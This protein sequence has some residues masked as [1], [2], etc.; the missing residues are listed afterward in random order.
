MGILIGFGSKA[1]QGK[2]TAAQV[3]VDHLDLSGIPVATFSF[4]EALYDECRRF[5]GMTTKDAP[6][7]QKVGMDRRQQNANYW[8]NKVLDGLDT[9][10]D[11]YDDGVAL[12]TDVRFPNEAE[13]IKKYGGYLVNVAR[14]NDDGTP[15]IAPDRPADHPSEISLDN[16]NWDFRIITHSGEEELAADLVLTVFNYIK[17]IHAE[18]RY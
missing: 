6:L 17:G 18:S 7:L 16:Y 11:K 10:F 15:F 1:R 13:E 5:H 9:Y 8:V 12:I 2:N 3:I 4:A 14:L